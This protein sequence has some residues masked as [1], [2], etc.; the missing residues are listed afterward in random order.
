MTKYLVTYTGGNQPGD[1]TQ[2]QT[3]QVMEAWTAWYTRLGEA[4]VDFGNPTGASRVI[5]PDGA[6]S[7]SGPGITGYSLINAESLDAAVELCRVHPHLDAGGT[8]T[9]SE[10]FEIG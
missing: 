5:A 4:V 2:E 1:M 7:D 6:V 9:I 10:T 3:A 8:I